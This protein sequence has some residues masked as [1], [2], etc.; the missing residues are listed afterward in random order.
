LIR[1]GIS[2]NTINDGV[3]S[4]HISRQYGGKYREAD[5]G[6]RKGSGLQLGGPGKRLPGVG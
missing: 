4:E 6:Y 3:R 1:V 2:D 5:K